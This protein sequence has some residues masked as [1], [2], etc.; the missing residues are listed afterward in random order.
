MQG[1]PG[2]PYAKAPSRYLARTISWNACKLL[3]LLLLLRQNPAWALCSVDVDPIVLLCC[4]QARC[5]GRPQWPRD[6]LGC[7]WCQPVHV[8]AASKSPGELLACIR[9]AVH[10]PAYLSCTGHD[11]WQPALARFSGRTHRMHGLKQ[12]HSHGACLIPKLGC[13]RE[14]PGCKV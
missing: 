12:A 11:R 6:F 2:E 3:L 13:I 8:C 1:K 9:Y 5:K 14:V 7:S 10:A 4:R